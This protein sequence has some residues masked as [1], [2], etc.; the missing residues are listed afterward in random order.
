MAGYTGVL[1]GFLEPNEF[2]S[3]KPGYNTTTY[4]R[5]V[6]PPA[7]SPV[8][9]LNANRRGIYETGFYFTPAISK[10]NSTY[11]SNSLT[12]LTGDSVHTDSAGIFGLRV[13]LDISTLGPK[14][15][16]YMDDDSLSTQVITTHTYLDSLAGSTGNQADLYVYRLPGTLPQGA[17]INY[18]R[19][20]KAIHSEE[21]LS[22]PPDFHATGKTDVITSFWLGNG[23]N[24]GVYTGVHGHRALNRVYD[25]YL[26]PFIDLDLVNMTQYVE[27]FYTNPKTNL[28]WTVGEVTVMTGGYTIKKVPGA[29]SESIGVNAFS[30]AVSWTVTG[31]SYVEVTDAYEYEI[32]ITPD[33]GWA[34]ERDMFN[35]Y[36]ISSPYNTNSSLI[37]K[38]LSSTGCYY[39][40]Q[41]RSVS[42]G[43]SEDEIQQVLAFG[44]PEYL[45]AVRSYDK[46]GN[47]S[48]WSEIRRFYGVHD[49]PISHFDLQTDLDG[50]NF[51]VVTLFGKKDPSIKYIEVSD[52]TGIAYYPSSD[53]WRCEFVLTGGLNELYIRGIPYNGIPTA[54]YRAKAKLET[55]QLYK[56]NIYNTFDDFGTLHGVDRLNSFNENNESYKERI[57][58]VFIHPAGSNLIG[59]HNSIARNL[60]LDYDDAA[61]TIVPNTVPYSGTID[62]IYPSVSALIDTN[63]ILFASPSFVVENE[64]HVVD[65]QDLSVGFNYFVNLNEDVKVHYPY[66]VDVPTNHYHIDRENNL[67]IFLKEMYS[68]KEVY[69]TYKK[70]IPVNIGSDYTLSTVVSSINAITYNGYTLFDAELS[71]NLDG[72]QSSDGILRGPLRIRSTDRYRDSNGD[73]QYGTKIR[74]TDIAIHRLSDKEFQNR[75]VNSDGTTLN[76]A[77]DGYI[78]TFKDIAHQTWDRV[79]L[80]KDVWD[81]VSEDELPNNLSPNILDSQ[82]GYWVSYRKNGE[83]QRMFFTQAFDI[84]FTSEYDKSRLVYK[85]IKTEDFKSGIGDG[86]DLKLIVYKDTTKEVLTPPSVYRSTVSWEVTG[87]LTDSS[88]LPNTVFGGILFKP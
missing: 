72:T 80:D 20:F 46:F 85:G 67:I 59:L 40:A 9:S 56:H 44:Y 15:A 51:P 17:T 65:P 70:F 22:S 13:F 2:Y 43:L 39:D 23:T 25:S 35:P 14:Q 58:D 73:I 54:Y 82:K 42:M 50:N 33:L 57:K 30:L 41:T 55:G 81:S 83:E 1:T 19:V 11:F 37:L 5:L 78:E 74:W 29:D 76:S 10:Y 87:Q 12:L 38:R 7:I 36:N 71:P 21:Y 53:S 26:Y 79:Q 6:S 49:R 64:Y 48:P 84:G 61:I 31:T 18:V 24:T 77:I 47:P 34:N 63:Y 8:A 4:D 28:P 3:Y 69:V 52:N 16:S 60:D 86:N 68:S 45:W 27:K 75:F 62:R 32:G 66:G 88:Y